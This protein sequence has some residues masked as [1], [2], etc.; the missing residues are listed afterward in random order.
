MNKNDITIAAR[1]Y[2]EEHFDL[3]L[4]SKEPLWSTDDV[5]KFA[6]K[7][8]GAEEKTPVRIS[9]IMQRLNPL[10]VLDNG[11]KDLNFAD[12]PEVHTAI[13][14]TVRK[15]DTGHVGECHYNVPAGVKLSDVGK[16][17]VDTIA[18]DQDLKND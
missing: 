6:A 2:S 8:L 9:A 15:N 5:I 3:G 7:L 4:E 1:N 12:R 13:V 10:D 17:L 14:I 16:A 18:A 11:K